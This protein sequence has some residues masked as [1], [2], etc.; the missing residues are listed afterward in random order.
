MSLSEEWPKLDPGTRRDPLNVLLVSNSASEQ[1][2]ARLMSAL[3]DRLTEQGYRV[4]VVLRALPRGIR[5]KLQ[6]LLRPD[7]KLGRSA[8]LADVIIVHTPLAISFGLVLMAKVRRKKVLSFVWDLHPESNKLTGSMTNPVALGAFRV[9]ERAALRLSDKLLVSTDDY[10]PHLGSFIE[11]TRVMPLWP[12]DPMFPLPAHRDRTDPATLKVAF[13]G[14]LNAIRGLERGALDLL[15]AWPTGRVEL[16][17]F[18]SNGCSAELRTMALHRPRFTLVE[19]GFVS[20]SELQHA[21]VKLD[22]GW[23]CLDPDFPLP[24]FPSKILAYLAAG[25]PVLYSGPSQPALD[26][27]LTNRGL[28]V[29]TSSGG[30]IMSSSIDSLRAEFDQKRAAYLAEMDSE[31]MHL[32]HLL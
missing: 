11:K 23:V 16:H 21:L 28:G 19:H 26:A 5:A 25:L 20:P 8:R 1:T 24:A 17:V 4:E 13:A 31:R 22:L 3:G 2:T 12:C 7:Q 32:D 29:S 14:Q 27:F 30:I 9:V 18:S 6:A 15:A 10:L